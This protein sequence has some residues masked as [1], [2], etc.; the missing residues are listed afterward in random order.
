M[1]SG[2]FRKT[3]PSRYWLKQY[4]PMVEEGT[5]AWIE[6]AE[7][8]LFRQPLPHAVVASVFA[9]R[10]VHLVLANY[11]KIDADLDTSDQYL[12]V[13]EGPASPNSEWKLPPRSMRI[14]RRVSAV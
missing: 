13:G 5:W 12:P 4:P 2:Q 6:V 7:S 8:K 10:E 1:F 3:G 14:L 11:G 9:N